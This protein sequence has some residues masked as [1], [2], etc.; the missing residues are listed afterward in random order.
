MRNDFNLPLPFDRTLDITK[1]GA[2]MAAQPNNHGHSVSFTWTA[3]TLPPFA[4]RRHGEGELGE[5]E[6]VK[7][8]NCEGDEYT[9]TIDTADRV[10]YWTDVNGLPCVGYTGGDL[11]LNLTAGTSWQY[12]VKFV[13]GTWLYYSD[14]WCV[15]NLNSSQDYLR[16]R[17]QNIDV[18]IAQIP[19]N[20][21]DAEDFALNLYL[22]TTELRP[23][24]E[25]EEEVERDLRFIDNIVSTRSVRSTLVVLHNCHLPVY[26]TLVRLQ[27]Y[28]GKGLQMQPPNE[29]NSDWYVI[30]ELDIEEPDFESGGEYSPTVRFRMRYEDPMTTTTCGDILT[31]CDEDY[32]VPI[33]TTNRFT[34]AFGEYIQVS[35]PDHTYPQHLRAIVQ[36]RVVGATEWQELANQSI[37]GLIDTPPSQIGVIPGTAYEIRV[38]VKNHNCEYNSLIVTEKAL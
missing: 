13:D 16:F 23:Q 12:V 15:E 22:M 19:H 25:V 38:Q 33:P 1:Q 24:H 4:I 8:R 18:G 31:P 10:R 36:Y 34:N 26:D 30:K 7:I 11:D 29:S 2:L 17:A 35:L 3:L 28:V 32:T 5:I 9:C 6:Y 27:H 14:Y 21:F 20:I 37:Q